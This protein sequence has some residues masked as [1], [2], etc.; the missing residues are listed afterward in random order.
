M[1]KNKIKVYSTFDTANDTWNVMNMN[2]Q[3]LF[4]GTI[5]GLENWLID[6]SDRYQEQKL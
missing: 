4:Y 3:C 1:D 6:N 5:D 2:N